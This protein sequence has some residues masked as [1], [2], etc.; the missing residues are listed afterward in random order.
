MGDLRELLRRSYRNGDLGNAGQA[1]KWER[2]R[3]AENT[4]PRHT[5][6]HV[7]GAKFPIVS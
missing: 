4:T 6:Q 3:T 5:Q 7:P 1:S 2:D